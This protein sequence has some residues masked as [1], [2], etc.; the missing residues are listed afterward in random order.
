[1][2]RLFNDVTY[3]YNSHIKNCLEGFPVIV[4][5]NFMDKDGSN[6]SDYYLLGIYNFNLSRDS[7]FNL[8]YSD[9][10]D[11]LDGQT[12]EDGFN[13]YKVKCDTKGELILKDDLWVVEIQ[14]NT[15]GFDFSQYDRSVLFPTDQ[16]N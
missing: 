16:A 8:G 3:K 4:L 13:I 10:D 12:L 11:A 14:E 7:Y 1:M 9:L 6:S 15:P 2:P 5:L